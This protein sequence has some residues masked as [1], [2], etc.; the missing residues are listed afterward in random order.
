MFIVKTDIFDSHYSSFS[1]VLV[2]DTS[3]GRT[4]GILHVLLKSE[5]QLVREALIKQPEA[6]CYDPMA[7]PLLLVHLRIRVNPKTL[8][9]LRTKLYNTEKRIGSHKNYETKKSHKSMGFYARG[10][11]VWRR[12]GFDDA[13]REFTS[14]VSDCVRIESKAQ[15]YMS[16]LDWIRDMHGSLPRNATAKK[17]FGMSL[18]DKM[19]FMKNGLEQHR[20]RSEY[21]GKRAAAQVEAVSPLVTVRR[22]M[23]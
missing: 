11:E 10:E 18:D 15:L 20:S 9:I 2:A 3:T 22:N 4:S 13:G 8:A 12:K 14:M 7:L 16:L 19:T 1:L 6:Y 17:Q 23:C 5:A 21:L